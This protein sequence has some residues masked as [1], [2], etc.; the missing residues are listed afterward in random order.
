MQ[1]C[2]QEQWIAYIELF[3]NEY[4]VTNAHLYLEEAQFSRKLC[5]YKINRMKS[6]IG[7]CQ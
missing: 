4:I 3:A 6:L 5:F 1:I 7:M 2:S